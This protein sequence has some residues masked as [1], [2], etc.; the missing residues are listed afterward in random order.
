MADFIVYIIRFRFIYLFIVLYALCYQLQSPIEPFLVDKLVDKTNQDAAISYGQV[1]SFF[2]AVQSIGSLLF[3]YLLDRFGLRMG[4]MLTSLACV[5]SFYLLSITDTLDML[6]LSKCPGY[7]LFLSLICQWFIC[8]FYC[9]TI[10]I[11][12]FSV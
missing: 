5:F 8:H 11:F 9:C 4:F 6:W 1:Q 2:A 3:G 12:V 7:K 10:Y